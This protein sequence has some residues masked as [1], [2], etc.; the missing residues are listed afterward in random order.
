MSHLDRGSMIRHIGGGMRKYRRVLR[1][2]GPRGRKRNVREWK[3]VNRNT[4]ISKLR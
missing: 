1:V 3:S 2:R 4:R